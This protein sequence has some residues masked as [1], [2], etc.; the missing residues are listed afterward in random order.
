MTENQCFSSMLNAE[1]ALQASGE[2]RRSYFD[3][4]GLRLKLERRRLSKLLAWKDP[5]LIYDASRLWALMQIP[6]LKLVVMVRDPLTWLAAHV[7]DTSEMCTSVQKDQG[8]CVD[9]ADGSITRA[10]LIDWVDWCESQHNWEECTGM[11]QATPFFSSKI[12]NLMTYARLALEEDRP[13]EQQPVVE[14]LAL[15]SLK[16]DPKG[17]FDRLTEGLG[18]RRI[19][20]EKLAPLQNVA[21]ATAARACRAELLRVSSAVSPSNDYL[22]ERLNQERKRLAHL[23][24]T[25]SPLPL[26]PFWKQ[27]L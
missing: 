26:T 23:L 24:K 22:A 18:A 16:E 27:Y 9:N 2:T 8:L 21:S 7:C 12:D 4:Y 1:R 20:S 25:L 15:D 10:P 6:A 3:A 17:F 11:P 14:L 19:P 13:P 5:T